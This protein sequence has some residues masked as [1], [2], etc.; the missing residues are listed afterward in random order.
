MIYFCRKLLYNLFSLI[1]HQYDMT[2][3]RALVPADRLRAAPCKRIPTAYPQM[4]YSKE[5]LT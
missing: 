2:K 3:A 1:W 4:R 5:E